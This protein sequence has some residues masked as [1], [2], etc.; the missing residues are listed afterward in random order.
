M[1]SVKVSSQVEA[2]VGKVFA[3]FTDVEHGAEHVS[4]IK[5]IEMLTPGKLR[6]GTRWSE[7]REVMGR[8]DEAEMEITAFESNTTYTITHHKGGVRIDTVLTFE[9][10]G[11][12]TKVTVDFDLANH[13]LPPGLLTPLGWALGGK[14]KEVLGHDLSDLKNTVERA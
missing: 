9:P 6:L 7:T 5:A 11:S 4:G 2:P 3:V 8:L 14:I 10:S 12:G 13:G 1:A